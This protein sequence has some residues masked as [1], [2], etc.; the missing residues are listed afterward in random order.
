M[1]LA[2]ATE[3][4]YL[5]GALFPTSKIYLVILISI[6][7]LFEISEMVFHTTSNLE[8]LIFTGLRTLF[9]SFSIAKPQ[10]SSN[11][12]GL[13]DLIPL[14]QF[15]KREKHPWKSDTLSNV[16]GFSHSS[17]GDFH[18]IKIAQTIPNSAKRLV[19]KTFPQF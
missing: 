16:A 19:L 17:S 13:R 8:F 10:N 7:F 14:I 18:V 12:D 2:I 5:L 15:Q 11:S 3:K 4:Y 6:I 9:Y 1:V